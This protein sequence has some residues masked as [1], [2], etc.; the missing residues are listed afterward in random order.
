MGGLVS[1]SLKRKRLLARLTR[2][3]RIL[4]G[5]TVCHSLLESRGG[6]SSFTWSQSLPTCFADNLC[7]PV[8]DVAGLSSHLFMHYCVLYCIV[9]YCVVEYC[10][11]VYCIVLYCIVLYCIVCGTQ[12]CIVL[13]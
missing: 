4:V 12:Y 6:G 3:F 10:I 5:N 1:G 7:R 9:L 8:G 2:V 11:V 13:Y